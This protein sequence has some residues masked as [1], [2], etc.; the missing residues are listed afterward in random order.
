MVKINI[1]EQ[2]FAWRK[3]IAEKGELPATKAAMMKAAGA[4]LSHPRLYRLAVSSAGMALR[5][6]PHFLVYSRLNPWTKGRE[7]PEAPRETFH[8]WWA[9]NRG[10]GGSH[11]AQ[12]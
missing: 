8:A 9:R 12:R 2:I 4:I 3:V 10:R 5:F 11:G 7:M 6:L 1:H